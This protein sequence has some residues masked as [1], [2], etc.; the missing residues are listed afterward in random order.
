MLRPCEAHWLLGSSGRGEK[1]EL[2][3]GLPIGERAGLRL[4]GGGRDC[5]PVELMAGLLTDESGEPVSKV[6]LLGEVPFVREM[7]ANW[8][9]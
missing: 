2:M 6:V 3:A 8:E 9:P 5:C 7:S 1:F 4:I